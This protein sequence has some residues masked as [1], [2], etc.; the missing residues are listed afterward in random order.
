MNEVLRV[1]DDPAPADVP[2]D[3]P[4]FLRW[5]GGPA[6][7]RVT[8]EHAERT[9]ALSVLLHGN[10]TSGARALHAWL[11]AGRR[12]RVSL[13]CLIGG[14]DAA[15][16]EPILSQ[17]FVPGERDLNRC[18]RPPFDDR[19]GRIAQAFLAVLR[20]VRPDCLVDIHNTSAPGPAFAV[21]PHE[22]R[23]HEALGALFCSNLVITDIALGAL[24]ECS[25]D[26]CPAIT[27]ECGAT[28]DPRAELIARE[29]LQRYLHDAD[30]GRR[31]F[32]DVDAENISR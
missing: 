19:P 15:L 9:R 20:S 3:F 10:E 11:R 14:V 1:F 18:F 6:L 8:G 5:L 2:A 29:G 23:A 27:V 16:S 7:L 17:R 22:D 4:G 26:P 21:A 31:E 25:G 13:L 30:V 12:P 28:A 24:M 32:A